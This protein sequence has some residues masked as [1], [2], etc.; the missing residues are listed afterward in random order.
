MK[1]S[2]LLGAALAGVLSLGA[3]ARAQGEKPAAK[4]D[5]KPAASQPAPKTENTVYV[6]MKTSMGDITLELNREKAPISVD[7]FLSYVDKGFYDGTIFHRVISD[8]MIQGGGYTADFQQKKTEKPIKNEWQNGLKNTKG[9]IAMARLGGQPDSATAQFFINVQ[10]N[11]FLDQNREGPNGAGYAVFGRVVEGM[12]T[13]DKIRHVKTGVKSTPQ[14]PMP[15]VPEETVTIVKVSRLD[16]QK[17]EELK[18]RLANGGAGGA[19][20]A[21][22]KK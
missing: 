12:D 6:L 4:P 20:G 22:P 13:V 19:T 2:L 15:N 17:A 5:E 8:F 11:P 14:G 10:D 9:T 16:A 7:N 1:L 21:A 3:T 18:A